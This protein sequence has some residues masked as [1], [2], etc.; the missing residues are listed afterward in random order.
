MNNAS[1]QNNYSMDMPIGIAGRIADCGFKNTLSPRC[2][3]AIPA[4][5]GVMKPLNNDYTIMLPRLNNGT[6]SLSTALITG[7]VFNATVNGVAITPVTYSTSNLATMQQIANQISNIPNVQSAIVGGI[8]DL[9]ITIISNVGT[10]T[11]ITS[12]A[13][14]GGASQ[15]TTT[16]SVAVGGTFFGVTQEIYNKQ[17]SYFAT[18]GPN[19]TLSSGIQSPYYAGQVAPT[20]TQGRIYVVP[21]VVVNSN[22]PV[23]LRVAANG[24]NTQLGAFTGISDGANTILAP[25]TTAIWREGNKFIGG[26]AVLELN[27]P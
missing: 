25:S 19:L 9:V 2:L 22:S 1:F 16:N 23:Y 18:Q 21:E 13:V 14:T 10:A 26:L 5:V 7:N 4:A 3:E 15:P 24:A 17:N 12:S 20:L 11:T 6:I 8:G 27:I